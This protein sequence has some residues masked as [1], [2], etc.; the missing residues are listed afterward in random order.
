MF[1]ATQYPANDHSINLESLTVNSLN[2]KIESR[3]SENPLPRQIITRSNDDRRGT[4]PRNLFAVKVYDRR[5][6][7]RRNM[8]P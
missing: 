1:E 6:A 7:E 3:R 5:V 2:E 8:T 4:M